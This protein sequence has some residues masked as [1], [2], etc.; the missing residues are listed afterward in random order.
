MC[1]ENTVLTVNL[2]RHIGVLASPARLTCAQHAA[3]LSGQEGGF[4]SSEIIS[5]SFTTELRLDR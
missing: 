1:E 5:C 4:N 2:K 3:L